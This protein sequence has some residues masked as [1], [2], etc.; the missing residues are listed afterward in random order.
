MARSCGL[1]PCLLL[2]MQTAGGIVFRKLPAA[3]VVAQLRRRSPDDPAAWLLM[4]AHM[5]LS[6]AADLPMLLAGLGVQP[7]QLARLLFNGV[8]PPPPETVAAWPQLSAATRLILNFSSFPLDVLL[9]LLPRLQV[10]CAVLWRAVHEDNLPSVACACGAVRSTCGQCGKQTFSPHLRTQVM[11]LTSLLEPA[12]WE[13]LLAPLA[14]C[15]TGLHTLQLVE[16][17]AAQ[18]PQ[19]PYLQSEVQLLVCTGLRVDSLLS[20]GTS[21]A[22][23][24]LP[25]HPLARSLPCFRCCSSCP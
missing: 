13:P 11:N 20:M 9:P 25:L 2:C 21:A 8:G 7:H 22:V 17:G 24:A 19:G 14:H 12:T 5:A 6:E 16:C 1:Q 3:S 15:A 23:L 10:R 4:C 18:L